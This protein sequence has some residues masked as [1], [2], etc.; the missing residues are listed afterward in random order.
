MTHDEPA[1]VE[2]VEPVQL[3]E[4]VELVELDPDAAAVRELGLATVAGSWVGAFAGETLV[5][6]AGWSAGDADAGPTSGNV[7]RMRLDNVF[8]VPDWRGRGLGGELVQA[9]EELAGLRAAD[10]SGRRAGPSNASIAVLAGV[11]FE[12]VITAEAPDDACA[13]WLS[14]LGFRGAGRVLDRR[15][16]VILDVP[17]AEAMQALGRGLGAGLRAGDLVILIGDLG[18]GKT[19]LTQGIGLGLG[20]TEPIT[21]PTFVLSRI[22]RGA[23][24]SPDL[25]HVDAYRLGG[26]EVDDI[27]LDSDLD[28]SVTVIEWGA[29]VAEQLSG[30][31]LEIEIRR[32]DDPTDDSREVVLRPVGDRWAADAFTPSSKGAVR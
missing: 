4:P 11:A 23:S 13:H 31:R 18:A 15:L 27:D 21:S 25:V 9:V 29:G 7:L 3:A 20:I 19:T 12:H 6:A 8:V 17:T 26:D 22:H 24:G 30:D 2:P 1:E 28:Q 16:P 32:S 5:G 14:G 10:L